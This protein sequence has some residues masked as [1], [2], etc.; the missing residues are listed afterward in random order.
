MI[1]QRVSFFCKEFKGGQHATK[2][3]LKQHVY[4][5]SEG[6]MRAHAAELKTL[7][8]LTTDELNTCLNA[9]PLFLGRKPV[10]VANNIQ[11]LQRYSFTPAQALHIYASRPNLAGYDWNSPLNIEKLE[12]LFL[13]LQL[14]TAHIA[15]NPALLS[16]SLEQKLG[17][18]GKLLYRSRAVLPDTPLA[19]S[20]YASY[21]TAFSD[22]KFAARFDVTS[23]APP[24]VYDAD[25]KRHWKHRWGFLKCE[26]GLSTAEISACRALLYT[27]LPDTL[28]PRWRF[29]MSLEATE[30]GFKAADHLTAM[31]TLSDENFVQT[32]DVINA[33]F[34]YDKDSFYNCHDWVYQV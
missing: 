33:G 18:R 11:K 4:Q 32:F 17:P 27:S 30:A 1:H 28:A 9:S 5:V 23:T 16:S 6:T 22:V 10:T 26:M 13:I 2:S 29:L 8:G 20:G 24:L 14:T 19:I 12:F 3:A 25:F 21:V 34:V 7:L 15:S 31:A